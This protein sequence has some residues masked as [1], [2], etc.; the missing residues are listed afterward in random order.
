MTLAWCG[1]NGKS[2]AAL[3]DTAGSNICLVHQC[4]TVSNMQLRTLWTPNCNQLIFVRPG[5]DF[6]GIPTHSAKQKGQLLLEAVL[7][8]T[9]TCILKT[10]PKEQRTQ[11][12]SVSTKITVFLPPIMTNLQLQNLNQTKVSKIG[13]SLSLINSTKLSY[14]IL[15]KRSTPTLQGILYWRTHQ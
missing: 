9:T 11:R 1:H 2:A 4:P 6:L 15:F 10:L 5:Q 8:R 13:P 14:K 3:V 12:I 7:D